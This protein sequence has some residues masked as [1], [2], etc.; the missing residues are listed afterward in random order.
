MVIILLQF[1]NWYWWVYN[2]HLF[3]WPRHLVDLVSDSFLK[4]PVGSDIKSTKMN[5]SSKNKKN[6]NS[7]I[8]IHELQPSQDP[9]KF[10]YTH[11]NPLRP[12]TSYQLSRH[13]ASMLRNL[14]NLPTALNIWNNNVSL[15]EE[16]K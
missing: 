4:F 2:Y 13:T 5:R 15:M 9:S 7:P 3:W 1:V 14:S 16:L 12:C 8:R 10:T 6:V 11:N